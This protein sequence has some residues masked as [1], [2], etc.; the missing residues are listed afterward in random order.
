MDCI[1]CKIVEGVI[2]SPHIYEDDVCIAIY[3]IN[4]QAKVHCLVMPKR[5]VANLTEA[6]AD[7]E[8]LGKLMAACARVAKQEGISE[9][10]YR[11]VTNCG[12][13][14]CQSVPHLHLHVLG[15]QMMADKMS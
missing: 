14:A 8:L 11:V 7:P 1:F 10:G 13:D 4:P 3:D 6:A 5:H 15:G 9:S 2:P 12:S